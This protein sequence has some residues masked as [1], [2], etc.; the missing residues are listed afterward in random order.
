MLLTTSPSARHRTTR[1]DRRFDR[2]FAQLAE[3]AFGRHSAA[4]PPSSTS[5]PGTTA[6]RAHRRPARRARGGAVDVS[7]AGRTL[8]RRRDDRRA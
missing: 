7:V 5:A 1:F 2:T 6:P 4:R 8:H 3:L